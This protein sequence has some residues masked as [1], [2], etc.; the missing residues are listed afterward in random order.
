MTVVNQTKFK[1]VKEVQVLGSD[2]PESWIETTLDQLLQTLE[3][4]SRPKGGVR[5]ITEG[6]PSIGGEHINENGGFRFDTIKFVP[7]NFFKQMNHGQIQTG[8]ILIVKDGATTGKVALVRDDFPYNPAAVNEH[9]FICRSAGGVNP[10]FLFYFLFSKEGQDRIL[11]NFRGSAQGGINQSFAPGTTVPLAP[12]AEQERIVS[13]VGDLLPRVNIV[14]ERLAKVPA[15]L[16]RF[17]Q[18]VLSAACSGRLTSDWRSGNVRFES[19]QDTLLRI[20]GNRAL[21]EVPSNEDPVELPE[22]PEEWIWSRCQYLCEPER[23]ITYG[24]IKLGPALKNGI[25][26]LR[27]SDVRWLY[28]DK[29]HIKCI[30]PEIAAGYYRTFLKGGEILITVRGSLGGVAV[31]PKEMAGCNI[32]REVAML[33]LHPELNPQFFSY[34][35]AS[36]WSQNWLSEVTKGVAYT[37]INIRDLKRLPLPVPPIAEQHEIVRR[38][39]TML[40]L[41]E[42]VEKRVATSTVRTENLIRAILA[43]AFRGELVPTEAELARREG[44]SFESASDLLVRIKTEQESKCFTATKK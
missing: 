7:Y 37:G 31:V 24:V 40:R 11:E 33:P 13:K 1:P 44:R 15:I 8:D 34:A 19:G 32:S 9:V 14:R 3:S 4:G 26:T 25:G 39:E 12:L 22:I 23:I 27:S 28:I 43:K 2:L 36:I 30:S 16:K 6:I 20:C 10:P 18:A 5:G 29:D 41:A 17:R 21:I 35:I 42:A 38:V